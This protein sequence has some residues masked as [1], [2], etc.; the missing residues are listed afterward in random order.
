MDLPY[1][2]RLFRY[3][4]Q[5]LGDSVAKE[6]RS[7][8]HTYSIYRKPAS[9]PIKKASHRDLVRDLVVLLGRN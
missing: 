3:P 1:L 9:N 6:P 7:P 4:K 5:S 8:P 2:L